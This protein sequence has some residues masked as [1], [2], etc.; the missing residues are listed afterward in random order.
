MA[1]CRRSSLTMPGRASGA[2]R[3]SRA[4]ASSSRFFFNALSPSVGSGFLLPSNRRWRSALSRFHP[5]H[6]TFVQFRLGPADDEKGMVLG[7]YQRRGDATKA[8]AE[9]AYQPEPRW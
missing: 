6:F 3:R 5:G 2:S 9:M 7:K 8:I 4:R 1:A